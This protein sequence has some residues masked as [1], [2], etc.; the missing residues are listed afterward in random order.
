[1]KRAIPIDRFSPRKPR[2]PQAGFSLLLDETIF[3]SGRS[4]PET[5]ARYSEGND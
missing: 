5:V 1:M 3:G 4:R 2:S